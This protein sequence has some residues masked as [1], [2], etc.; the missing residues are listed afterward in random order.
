MKTQ[1]ETVHML[2]SVYHRAVMKTLVKA[3][4]PA[5]PAVNMPTASRVSIVMLKASGLLSQSVQT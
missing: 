4:Q 2:A 1:A 5:K 3:Y